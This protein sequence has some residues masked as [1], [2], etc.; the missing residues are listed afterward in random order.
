MKKAKKRFENENYSIYTGGEKVEDILEKG[1]IVFSITVKDL[2]LDLALRRILSLEGKSSQDLK[3]GLVGEL[4]TFFISH[5]NGL[6]ESEVTQDDVLTI[7]VNPTSAITKELRLYLLFKQK[8]ENLMAAE[9]E[10]MDLLE[11]KGLTVN[12]RMKVR[13]AFMNLNK[14]TYPFI[15]P[16]YREGGGGIAYYKSGIEPLALYSFNTEQEVCLANAI[17]ENTKNTFSPNDFV[18]DFRYACRIFGIKS[19]WAN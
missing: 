11:K 2:A 19:D 9:K 6:L 3:K 1:K 8:Q 5:L 18:M 17:Y 7:K 4:L 12:E 13:D 10:V 15:K 16:T 14:E